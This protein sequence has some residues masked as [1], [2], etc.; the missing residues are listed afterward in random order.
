LTTPSHGPRLPVRRGAGSV[1]LL[2]QAQ[3][4]RGRA[5]RHPAPPRAA[6]DARMC[7]SSSI[8]R[9]ACELFRGAIRVR[10]TWVERWK[11]RNALILFNIAPVT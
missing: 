4:W 3:L 8:E 2:P 1:D 11:L 7:K 6:S 5:P 9:A 10:M